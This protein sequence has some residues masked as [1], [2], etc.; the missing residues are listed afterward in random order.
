MMER[1]HRW[2]RRDTSVRKNPKN[3]F[4]HTGDAPKS[5]HTCELFLMTGFQTVRVWSVG[6]SDGRVGKPDK[7]CFNQEIRALASSLISRVASKQPQ[8]DVTRMCFIPRSSASKL[9]VPV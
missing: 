3:L 4:S 8:C 7:P 1:A 2:E 6:G 9:I 5:S